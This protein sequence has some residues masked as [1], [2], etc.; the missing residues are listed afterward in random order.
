MHLNYAK[1]LSLIVPSFNSSAYLRKCL[2]SLIIEGEDVEIIVVDD[3]SSD[4]TLAI[5][6]EYEVKYPGVIKAISQPNKGHG[7]AINTGLS[8]ARG[9]Y[10]KIVDSDDWLNT[11]GLKKIVERLKNLTEKPDMLLNNF[12]IDK[13]GKK[14]KTVMHYRKSLPADMTLTWDDTMRL[15]LGRY[16]M[17]HAVIY[18]KEVL[19]KSRLVLPEHTFYVDYIYV[20]QPFPYV[21]SIYYMDIDLYHYFIGREDQTV[22]EQNHI[23]NIHHQ[24]AVN[25][26]MMNILNEN[27]N[28]NKIKSHRLRNYMV[29]YLTICTVITSA[30]FLVEGS[31]SSLDQ[32]TEL[33]HYLKQENAQ[34]YQKV[35][36]GYLGIMINLPTKS[37]RLLSS[38]IYKLSRKIIGFS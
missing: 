18:K 29:S 6:T 24:I 19:I 4:E 5:A 38:F 28:G 11:N 9:L 35:R 31:K 10:I 23:K 1:I 26:Q 32:K 27:W 34:I 20:Y 2:D 30:L 22:T 13:V 7:G 33:W 15:K 36:F 16:I 3:G 21:E 37:G 17:M 12:I 25:K 14:H 8:I